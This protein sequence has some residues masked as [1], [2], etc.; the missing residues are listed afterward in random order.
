MQDDLR[1]PLYLFSLEVTAGEQPHPHAGSCGSVGFLSSHG[2]PYG[3]PGILAIP[4]CIKVTAP[5]R[6]MALVYPALRVKCV[7]MAR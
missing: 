3:L 1:S 4:Y 6:A 2:I 7:A 5:V